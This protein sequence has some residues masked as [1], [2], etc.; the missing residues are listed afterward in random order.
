MKNWLIKILTPWWGRI[1]M[2][3]FLS[4]LLMWLVDSVGTKFLLA[5]FLLTITVT[6][7]KLLKLW[8]EDHH[9]LFNS[10]LQKSV[11]LIFIIPVVVSIFL[12]I[13]QLDF[14]EDTLNNFRFSLGWTGKI[15]YDNSV[16]A[17]PNLPISEFNKSYDGNGGG[18]GFQSP[19]P[20]YFGLMAIAGA[21]LLKRK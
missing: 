20:I 11:G 10:T 18:G 17:D 15:D 12:F 3:I 7:L 14:E 19:L 2:G 21:L 1:V 8:I 5:V 13:K 16:S 4:T 6:T 9:D